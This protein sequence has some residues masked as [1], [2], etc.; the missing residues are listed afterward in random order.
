MELMA[1]DCYHLINDIG[2]KPPIIVCGL[3]MGGYVTFALYRLYPQLFGGLIL[4]S[5]RAAPDSAEGKTNREAG[6][7]NVLEHGVP[8]IVDGMFTK[9]VSPKTIKNKPDLVS[10]I[11]EIMLETSVNGVVGAL[12]GMR[13]R[14]DSTP[15]LPHI[16]CPTLIIHGEDDQLIPV[17]EAEVMEQ[18][19]PN[20]QLIILPEAG[21]LA[22]M[23]QPDKFNQALV[24]FLDTLS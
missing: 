16:T 17:K 2:I 14:I 4:T 18:S 23:E 6:I 8:Y 13:D 11:R 24:A 9:L 15:L 7:K 12:Q 5:T 20:S 1:E 19:I 10:S 22:N 3:S 21:H